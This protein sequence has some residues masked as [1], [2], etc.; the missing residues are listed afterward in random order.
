[1]RK[2]GGHLT[3]V[4]ILFDDGSSIMAHKLVLASASKFFQTLFSNPELGA[5][6]IIKVEATPFEMGSILVDSVYSANLPVDDDNVDCLIEG[7]RKLGFEQI[8][9]TCN[10]FK[11]RKKETSCSEGEMLSSN[12]GTTANLVGV[13][14]T[15]K[16][17]KIPSKSEVHPDKPTLL[18][19]KRKLI[20]KKRQASQRFR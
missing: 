16:T 8:E 7:A 4:S 2:N 9:T 15:T 5:H 20:S 18:I 1:M 10:Q 14:K 6:C 13:A 12:E 3:D 19:E 11:L 17:N